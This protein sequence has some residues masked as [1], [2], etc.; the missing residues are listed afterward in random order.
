MNPAQGIPTPKIPKK[1]PRFLTVDEVFS[2]LTSPKGDG[3]LVVRDRA[4]LELFYASGVRLSELVE[5]N[6][7]NLD[8]PQG[9]IRVLGKGSKERMVPFGEKA[10]TAIQS[11]LQHRPIL[12]NG[13][14]DSKAVFLNKRGGRLSS[15]AVER[16]VDKY[17]H[18]SGIQKKVTPH[19]LRHTFATHMMNG[20]ADMR[21]LQELLG[22]SSLSTTQRYTHVELDKLMQVY[23]KAHPKA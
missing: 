16:L 22:H 2:L 1:V 20:G 18:Q 3:P 9:M 4:I 5:L 10:K 6:L 21:G 14:M 13:K 7:E 17:L 12:L 15:R 23:D 8:M 11:Y 19:T